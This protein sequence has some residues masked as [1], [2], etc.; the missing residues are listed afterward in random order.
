MGLVTKPLEEQESDIGGWL[1]GLMEYTEKGKIQWRIM[2]GSGIKKTTNNFKTEYGKYTIELM[3]E[4]SKGQQYFGVRI[5]KKG[6][7]SVILTDYEC[8]YFSDK[9][10]VSAKMNSFVSR[11]QKVILSV[12]LSTHGINPLETKILEKILSL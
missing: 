1:K 11:M 8:D 2:P 4:I 7:N 3:D 10:V 5:R 12:A 6:G 9:L